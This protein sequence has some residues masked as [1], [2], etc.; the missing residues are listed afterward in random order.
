M[1][2]QKINVEKS[3]KR[4]PIKEYPERYVLKFF[5]TCSN[6]LIKGTKKRHYQTRNFLI[7]KINLFEK[8]TNNFQINF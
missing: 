7:I 3:Y 8:N 5:K 6:I 4:I 1:F 2:T